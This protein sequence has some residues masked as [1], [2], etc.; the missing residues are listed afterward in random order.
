MDA[1]THV[2]A[3]GNLVVATD[4]VAAAL[5]WAP[6]VSPKPRRRPKDAEDDGQ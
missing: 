2:T 5:G 1:P 4:A 6:Y 3:S